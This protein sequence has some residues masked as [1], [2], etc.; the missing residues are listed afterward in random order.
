MIWRCELKLDTLLLCFIA[1]LYDIHYHKV[2]D[3]LYLICTMFSDAVS[4]ARSYNFVFIHQWLHS[5]LLCPGLF[6]SS[7]IFFIQSVG[8]LGRVI[9]PSQG[10]YLHRT[11]QAQNKRTQGIHALSR[12]RTHDPTARASEYSSCLRPRG[13]CDQ[14]VHVIGVA[15]STEYW[16]RIRKYLEVRET[17]IGFLT[18]GTRFPRSRVF[19]PFFN[20]KFWEEVIGRVAR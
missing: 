11:T 4:N 5:P 13:H 10:R 16:G 17:W 2:W 9:N 8:L 6:F 7:V 14:Q 19:N 3:L 15:K 20:K 12:I 1:L 18:L